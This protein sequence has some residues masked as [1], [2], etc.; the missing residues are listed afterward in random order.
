MFDIYI[1]HSTS[2]AFPTNPHT[3]T[4]KLS[5]KPPPPP[6]TVIAPQVQVSAASTKPGVKKTTEKRTDKEKEKIK[7]EKEKIKKEKAKAKLKKDKEKTRL[8][9]QKTK[10]SSRKPRRRQGRRDLLRPIRPGARNLG[11]T[12]GRVG[13]SGKLGHSGSV[14]RG[15]SEGRELWGWMDWLWKGLWNVISSLLLEEYFLSLVPFQP[16]QSPLRMCGLWYESSA[17]L[18]FHHLISIDSH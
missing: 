9:K 16:S 18:N 15:L 8:K 6:Y 7:K 2:P 13:G 4:Y 11:G 14:G 1:T 12:I 3:N 10:I 5:T 17:V